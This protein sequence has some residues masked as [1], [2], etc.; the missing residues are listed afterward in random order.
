[1]KNIVHR[2]FKDNGFTNLEI[3]NPVEASQIEFWANYSEEAINFYL[4]LFSDE[5]IKESFLSNEVPA[6]FNAIKQL[7][8]GYDERMDK[9]LSLIVFVK[10]DNNEIQ[11]NSEKIFEIEEDPYFF[12]KYVVTYHEDNYIK[13]KNRFDTSHESSNE[14]L[15]KVINDSTM[16][17]DYKTNENNS[18]EISLYEICVK[19]MVK[20]PFIKL[21]KRIEKIE[22]LNEKINEELSEKSLLIFKN[23]LLV[24]DINDEKVVNNILLI[25]EDDLK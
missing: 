7:K 22:N 5:E 11:K 18:D 19:L 10:T 1:M 25:V 16:F 4:V 23:S 24:T 14:I 21:E 20:I 9:N 17:L 3:E 15:N 6:Y 13:L 2:I 8:V 12:K